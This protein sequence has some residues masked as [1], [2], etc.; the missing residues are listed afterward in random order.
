MYTLYGSKGSGSATAEMGL[1]AAGLEYRIVN[2]ASWE[3]GPGLDELRKVNPLAQIPTLVL[4][5]GSVMSESAAILIHLGLSA[6]PGVLLPK[7]DAARAQ[8]IR[9]LVYIPANC[10]SCI[11]ILDYPDRFTSEQ[12]KESLDAVR[13]GTRARLHRHWEIFADTFQATPF[14]N[15]AAP[16]ALD[17]LAVVV[18]KWAGARA[19]LKEHRPQF[20]DLLQRIEAHELVAPVFRAHWDA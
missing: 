7:D 14:L 3:P 17:F 8:A 16:G 11:T 4:P 6:K 1:R 19:H 2:A 10:Y 13:A 15:G 9:G 5:D 18:S 12:D 20:A